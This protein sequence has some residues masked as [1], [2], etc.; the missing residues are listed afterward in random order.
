[1]L[2]ALDEEVA[3]PQVFGRIPFD[4]LKKS[5]WN[6][7]VL[8]VDGG[9]TD[10]T[11]QIAEDLGCSIINQWGKGKGAGMRQAFKKFLESDD[12]VLVMLDSDGTYSP[13]E[14]GLL[15]EALP[16][17]GVV[18][19]DRLRGDLEPEAM[20]STNWLG[21]HMLTWFAVALH[22]KRVND[23]CSGFWAFSRKAVNKMQLNSMRFEIEAE[24]Y[25]CCVNRKI[26][27][28]HI[29]ISY[30][31]RVGQAKLG[32]VR[33]GGAIAKKLI[34]RKIFPLPHEAEK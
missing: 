29:P 33:D 17:G 34:I 25:T 14:I 5:G 30:S 4:E 6:S 24:M 3:L 13:E 16:K 27:I 2:P 1:M 20:T 15:I 26:P 22:G 21:N 31:K 23:L 7:R 19:G 18:I 12:D 8:V 28:R 32:S 10:N 11:I 9:S